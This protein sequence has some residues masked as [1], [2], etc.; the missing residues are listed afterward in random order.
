MWKILQKMWKILQKKKNVKGASYDYFFVWSYHL[1][2]PAILVLPCTF[3]FNRLL[4]YIL[5]Y[6]KQ[7]VI[8]NHLFITRYFM[9]DFLWSAVGLLQDYILTI[10]WGSFKKHLAAV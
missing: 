6:Y 9:L 3:I 5:N 8:E 4:F 1:F 2:E 7:Y 10:S